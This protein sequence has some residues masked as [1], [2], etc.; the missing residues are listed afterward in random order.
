MRSLLQSFTLI[1]ELLRLTPNTKEYHKH[2]QQL[3]TEEIEVV[4]KIKATEAVKKCRQ[5]KS[6]ERTNKAKQDCNNNNDIV[7]L[8]TNEIEIE[9]EDDKSFDT[10]NNSVE[11]ITNEIEIKEANHKH[12]NNNNK[13]LPNILNK[14]RR[15]K[16]KINK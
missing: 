6:I 7:E 12:D 10:C 5:R 4:T 15:R 1:S 9:Q 13:S 11:L 2:K 14:K 8:I 3:S 16:H